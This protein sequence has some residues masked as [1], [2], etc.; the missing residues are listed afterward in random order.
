MG[1]GQVFVLL[2]LLYFIFELIQGCG[3]AIIYTYTRLTYWFSLFQLKQDELSVNSSAELTRVTNELK[4]LQVK[5]EDLQ[6][7]FLLF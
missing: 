6:V 7:W 5:Y 2:P 3:L 1:Y 4:E